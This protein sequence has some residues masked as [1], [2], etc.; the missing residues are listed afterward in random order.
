[1]IVRNEEEH[2]SDCLRCV[3][4]LVDEI[5]IVDTG[6]SDRT[7]QI[8]AIY[9]KQI[10]E[11][12]W[13]DDFSEA[14][15]FA[16]SQA[17]MEYILWL[18]ADDRLME[19]DRG[20]LRRLKEHLQPGIDSVVMEYNLAMDEEGRP[21]VI[22]RLHRLV[23]RIKKYMWKEPIHEY[24]DVYDGE[25]IISDIAVTH[26]RVGDHSL[27]NL[28][29]LRKWCGSN[30]KLQG[31]LLY[32]Y[33]SE[34]ADLGWYEKAVVFFKRYLQE[35]QGD[36][37]GQL[38]ACARL[39]D[40][41][42]KLGHSEERLQALLKSF[43][44]GLPHAEFCSNLG[45]CFEEREEW[46]TAVYWY[47]QALNLAK[48][49]RTLPLEN[50]ILSTWLPHCRLCVCYARLG[51]LTKAYEHNA[52][53]LVYLPNDRNLIANKVNLEQLMSVIHME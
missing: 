40:C 10:I 26:C 1:M 24:L 28:E 38:M 52:S 12:N 44:Y 34:H 8:A 3:I 47:T 15:N 23:R 37:E 33:A 9:T 42:S 35:D 50:K 11:F 5:I 7:R 46:E 48:A 25:T 41:Y 45:S 30:G 31:R 17:S 14:R 32:Y 4:D 20:K 2:L 43:Q 22:T 53:A 18:D 29:I 51:N 39:A 21:A 36:R 6:S 49:P 27:R 19:V 16:F 13:N